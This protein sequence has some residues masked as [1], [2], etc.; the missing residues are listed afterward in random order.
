M[1][2][3][4]SRMGYLLETIHPM[5]GDRALNNIKKDKGQKM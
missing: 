4:L 2:E 3:R 1:I 5:L